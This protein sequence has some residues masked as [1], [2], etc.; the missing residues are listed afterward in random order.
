MPPAPVKFLAN[1]HLPRESCQSDNG[2][3][4]NETIPGEAH[5]FHGIHLKAEERPGKHHHFAR[6]P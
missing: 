4:D 1:G 5:R 3:G 2:K 6:R